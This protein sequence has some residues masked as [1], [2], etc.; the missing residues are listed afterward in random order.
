MNYMRELNAFRDWALLNRP[1]T[2]EVAL[3]HSL[4]SINNATGWVDW[5]TVPNQTLQLLTGLS[6]Q[7]LERARNRLI[8]RG[9]I[10][11]QKGHSNHAGKYRMVSISECQKV[12]TQVGTPIGTE[13]G[14]LVGTNRAQQWAQTGQNG[15]TLLDRDLDRDRSGVCVSNARA[16]ASE[17]QEPEPSD[18]PEDYALEN[19]Y[20]PD[21]FDEFDDPFADDEPKYKDPALADPV[22]AEV[23]KEFY[24]RFRLMPNET[25]KSLIKRC[26]DSGMSP[27]LIR[28]DMDETKLHNGKPGYLMTILRR[29]LQQGIKTVEQEQEQFRL[30]VAKETRTKSRDRPVVSLA[31]RQKRVAQAL[32]EFAAEEGP[33]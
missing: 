20:M 17:V 10:E 3:W 26:I 19:H 23:L 11:Y 22:T 8:Q 31:E 2:G 25:Q 9:L 4:M 24:E 5:F 28:Y 12:G 14:T 29:Q 7:G 32:E 15:S 33:S 6:R 18:L 21:D 27:E 30:V 1:S 13:I 16:R